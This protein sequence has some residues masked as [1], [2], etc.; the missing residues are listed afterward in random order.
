MTTNAPCYGPEVVGEALGISYDSALKLTQRTPGCLAFNH[1]GGEK[2][3]NGKRRRYRTG[4]CR[5]ASWPVCA[6]GLR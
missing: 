2:A 3:T 5:K 4:A 6:S 1:F